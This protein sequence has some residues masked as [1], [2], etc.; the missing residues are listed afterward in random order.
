MRSYLFA[1]LVA[2]C[3]APAFAQ[4]PTVPA[5]Q[6]PQSVLVAP[7][8]D[9][10][11][12]TGETCTTCRRSCRQGLFGRTIDRTVTASRAVVAAPVRVATA[13]FRRIRA[14]RGCCCR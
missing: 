12:C 1:I 3:V 10:G 14:R 11:N 9:S 5:A 2:F 7:P 8:Q 6:A 4:E 13:P